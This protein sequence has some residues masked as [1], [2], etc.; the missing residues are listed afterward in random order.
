MYQRLN[1]AA[2]VLKFEGD[3]G[4]CDACAA[5]AVS[6]GFYLRN[7]LMVPEIIRTADQEGTKTPLNDVALFVHSAEYTAPF[8]LLQQRG[9]CP[10]QDIALS[11]QIGMEA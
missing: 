11:T 8:T 6:G 10:E 3:S 9:E 4:A 1:M 7:P 2:A 5:V